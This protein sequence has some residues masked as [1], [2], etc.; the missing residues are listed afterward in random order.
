MLAFLLI[1]DVKTDLK[2]HL[3]FK[4][5]TSFFSTLT[6]ACLLAT[7]TI[8]APIFLYHL[9]YHC[10]ATRCSS[11]TTEFKKIPCYELHWYVYCG[12]WS[13]LALC[14]KKSFSTLS[15]IHPLTSCLHWWQR[16][17][18]ADNLQTNGCPPL[19]LSHSCP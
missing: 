18:K 7:E 4:Y 16:K 11:M 8:L 19:C 14:F 17:Y 15:L 5:V 2:L 13:V 12:K 10:I 6:R 9:Q 1:C 3:R